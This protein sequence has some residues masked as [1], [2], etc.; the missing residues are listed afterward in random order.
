M[1]TSDSLAAADVAVAVVAVTDSVVVVVVISGVADVDV[2]MAVAVA[3]PMVPRL[4]LLL[5]PQLNKLVKFGCA[6]CERLA[7]FDG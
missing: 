1:V 6:H 5:H 3:D 4:H 7:V 2:V